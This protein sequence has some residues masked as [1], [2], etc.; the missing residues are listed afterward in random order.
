MSDTNQQL[1]TNS[2]IVELNDVSPQSDDINYI[3][4]KDD[5]IFD[6]TFWIY[7]IITL[8]FIII[9][10]TLILGSAQDYQLVIAF[11]WMLATIALMIIVYYASLTWGPSCNDDTLVCVIDQNSGCFEAKNRVWLFVNILFIILLI[12]SV[13]WA[14]EFS[15]LDSGPFRSLSGV[16]ILLGGLILVFLTSSHPKSRIIIFWISTFYLLIWFALT[17]Y[18]TV[19]S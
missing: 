11:F 19:T 13:M 3:S 5:R 8:F 16:L 4:I 9:G 7:F 6:R 12:L 14:G 1:E 18:V 2:S 17:F 10:I 15:N